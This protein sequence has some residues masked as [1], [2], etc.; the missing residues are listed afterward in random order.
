MSSLS[1]YIDPSYVPEE[2]AEDNTPV[3]KGE[4][5]GTIMRAEIKPTRTNGAR[6]NIG[7]RIDGPSHAGKWVWGG[8][9]LNVPSSEKATTIGKR[10]FSSLCVATGFPKRPPADAGQFV[11]KRVRIR[12]DVREFNGAQDNEIKSWKKPQSGP[13]ATASFGQPLPAPMPQQQ[14][15]AQHTDPWGGNRAHQPQQVQPQQAQMQQAPMQPQF[16]GQFGGNR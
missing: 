1:D 2:N 10:Q 4:Y 15:Q 14:P 16:N 8:I 3:P 5:E 13:P 6:L 9:N 12:V 11:E 7:V